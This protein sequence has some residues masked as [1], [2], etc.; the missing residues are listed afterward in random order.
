MW[1]YFHW[2]K[3]VVGFF[4]CLFLILEKAFPFSSGDILITQLQIQH[5]SCFKLV[6]GQANLKGTRK[7]VWSAYLHHYLNA[8]L[9][10]N[11]MICSPKTSVPTQTPARRNLKS[12]WCLRDTSGTCPLAYKS[13][14]SWL[15]KNEY[16]CVTHIY[17]CYHSWSAE[18]YYLTTVQSG[19]TTQELLRCRVNIQ[20]LFLLPH[21]KLLP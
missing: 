15:F 8:I 5:F 11:K 4:V 10:Y 18:V 2:S 13:W 19:A 6:P 3:L 21:Q 20:I 7:L 1:K 9:F 12:P 17:K 16:V 14:W